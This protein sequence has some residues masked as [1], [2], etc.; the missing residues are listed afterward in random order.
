MFLYEDIR[1][2]PWYADRS[3]E[4]IQQ[5]WLDGKDFQIIATGQYCSRREAQHFMA[6]GTLFL[7]V[8][9]L[10]EHVCTLKVEEYL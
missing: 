10:G 3:K 8:Y 4:D 5:A 7:N 1:L 6:G 9:E 2:A